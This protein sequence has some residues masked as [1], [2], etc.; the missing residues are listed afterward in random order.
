MRV[1]P[2]RVLALDRL[3]ANPDNPKKPMGRRYSRALQASL[4]EFGFSGVF[5]VAENLDGTY[6]VLDGNTR[7]DR[8]DEGGAK[9][10]PCVVHHDMAEGQPGW[11]E[12]RTVFC[13]NYDR[14]KKLFD[15]DAV[16]AQLRDLAQQG[17]D[18]GKL[19]TL[20]ATENLDRLLAE[21]EPPRAPVPNTPLKVAPQSSLVLYGPAEDVDAIKELLKRI[22]GRFASVFKLRSTLEQADAFADLSDEAFCVCFTAALRRYQEQRGE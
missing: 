1:N 17:A 4:D 11:Q 3:K 18:A 6:E 7:L 19:G 20:T 22:R 21:L 2:V 10:V 12:R 13:L 16:L 5:N 8:L 14:A 9:E 15:E